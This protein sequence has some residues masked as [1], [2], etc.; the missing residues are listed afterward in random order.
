[1]SS[2]RAPRRREANE[3]IDYVLHNLWNID[4]HSSFHKSF[5]RNTRLM[6]DMKMRCMLSSDHELK[7]DFKASESEIRNMRTLCYYS[8]YLFNENKPLKLCSSIIKEDY[9]KFKSHPLLWKSLDNDDRII[10]K[11]YL[12]S[13][14]LKIVE[15]ATELTELNDF[16]SSSTIPSFEC[17]LNAIIEENSVKS[18]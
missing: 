7:D 2:Q 9:E 13:P 15:P 14:I 4:L 11:H 1:M 12:D 6:S 5:K 3:D 17:N 8:Y 18:F 10:L 16:T